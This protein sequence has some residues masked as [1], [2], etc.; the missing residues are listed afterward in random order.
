MKTEKNFGVSTP[1]SVL[2]TVVRPACLAALAAALLLSA[3][4]NLFE[5]GI[6][7]EV[8]IA[9]PEVSVETPD[10]GAFIQ[11]EV[12]F[13]GE[14]SDDREVASVEISFDRGEWRHV[15]SFEPE[16]GE[17]SYDVDTGEFPDGPLSVRARATD[18]ADKTSTTSELTYYVDNDAPVV[19]VTAPRD[20]ASRGFNTQVTF[21]VAAADRHAIEHFGVEVYD[22]D[23]RLLGEPVEEESGSPWNFTFRSEE[24]YPDDWNGEPFDFFFYFYAENEGE[25]RSSAFYHTDDVRGVLDEGVTADQL[26]ARLRSDDDQ[27]G[28]LRET[29][30]D[31][32]RLLP[33][34][35]DEDLDIPVIRI[36]NPN[37]GE[38]NTDGSVPAELEGTD[39]SIQ[40]GSTILGSVRDDDALAPGY[41]KIKLWRAPDEGAENDNEPAEWENLRP[42]DDSTPAM[43]EFEYDLDSDMSGTYLLRLK[44]EDLD[45]T[46][47]ETPPIE[48]N[49]TRGAPMLRFTEPESG[50]YHRGQVEIRGV[51]SHGDVQ[52]ELSIRFQDESEEEDGWAELGRAP[53][54]S[55]DGEAWTIVLVPEGTDGAPEGAI[56]YRDGTRNIEVRAEV[57]ESVTQTL[58]LVFDNEPPEVAF[59]TPSAD[60]VLNGLYRV[61]GTAADNQ[62]VD[63]VYLHMAPEGAKAPES[64]DD[65]NLTVNLSGV[66]S[67]NRIVDTTAAGVGT[68]GHDDYELHVQAVDRAGNLGD[69]ATVLI[70]VDQNANDPVFSF[71]GLDPQGDPLENPG[72]NLFSSDEDA[73]SYAR[74]SGTV[75]DDDG[76]DTI[77]VR[78]A[79]GAP[80]DLSEDDWDEWVEIGTFEGSVEAGID[81]AI[82]AYES[83]TDLGFSAGK[84]PYSVQFQATDIGDR[85]N[86]DYDEYGGDF[87]ALPPVTV[88]SDAIAFVID[89]ENPTI[90]LTSLDTAQATVDEPSEIPG[91]YLRDS[92]TL[93][94]EADD[95]VELQTV[96][97]RTRQK[98][99]DEDDEWDG[100]HDAELDGSSPSEWSF[101]WPHEDTDEEAK[102]LSG[103]AFR[104]EYRA[105]DIFGK[106]T[107]ND[108]QLIVDNEPPEVQIDR[109]EHQDSDGEP[110]HSTIE[111]RGTA[112]DDRRVGAVYYWIGLHGDETGSDVPEH[113][114]EYDDPT[115]GPWEQ[116]DSNT[117]WSYDWDTYAAQ[118]ETLGDDFEEDYRPQW[119][120][121]HVAAID[122]A[123]NWI[124][125]VETVDVFVDQNA[126]RPEIEVTNI[127]PDADGEPNGEDNYFGDT[128]VINGTLRAPNEMSNDDGA[129]EVRTRKYDDGTDDG[130]WDQWSGWNPI[131]EEAFTGTGTF[132]SFSYNISGLGLEEGRYQIAFRVSDSEHL[133]KEYDYESHV[134]TWSTAGLGVGEGEDGYEDAAPNDD[135]V[136]DF[137]LNRADPELQ[138][139]EPAEG[140]Y[141]NETFTLSGS[142]EDFFGVET[143]EVRIRDVDDQD[144]WSERYEVDDDSDASSDHWSSWTYDFEVGDLDLAEGENRIEV[145]ATDVFGRTRERERTVVFDESVPGAPDIES[146]VEVV[147]GDGETWLSGS[148]RTA[149]GTAQDNVSGIDL[150]EWR[151]YGGQYNEDYAHEPDNP[152]AGSDWRE[153]SGGTQDGEYKWDTSLNLGEIG[154]GRKT[155]EVRAHDR[156]GNTSD[157]AHVVFGV[158][159]SDPTVAETEIGS[160]TAARSD[161]FVLGGEIAD[162][163]EL[164]TVSV[165]QE[166]VT[167]DE[168]DPVDVYSGDFSGES[169]SWSVGSLPRDPEA[170]DPSEASA[171]DL[172]DGL[173]LYTVTVT[174]VAGRT[175][176]LTREI[177][178]DL[179][180]PEVVIGAPPETGYRSGDATTLDGTV[181]DVDQLS[182][183]A[184]VRYWVGEQGDTPPGDVAGGDLDE[185]YEVDPT[186]T[187]QGEA[188]WNDS[189]D[190]VEIGEGRM[191]LH[192]VALDEAG[193]W[194]EE[195]AT[196][197]FIVDQSD[198]EV[199]ITEIDGGEISGDTIYRNTSFSLG[200]TASDD[201]ELY[202]VRIYQNDPDA[203]GDPIAKI[204]LTGETSATWSV[205][206]LPRDPDSPDDPIS[207]EDLQDGEFE[208]RVDVYDITAETGGSFRSDDVSR[209]IT[210]DVTPPA[211]G[212]G[213]LE[214]IVEID[215]DEFLN[216]VISFAADVSS[217]GSPLVH[218]P[219]KWWILDRDSDVPTFDTEFPT[220]EEAGGSFGA[221]PYETDFDTTDLTD[222]LESDTGEFTIYFVAKDE[223]G[224]E[225]VYE[226]DVTIDQTS[227]RPIITF[228]PLEDNDGYDPEGGIDDQGAYTDRDAMSATGSVED[229]DGLARLQYRFAEEQDWQTL[230]EWDQDDEVTSYDWELDL[231]PVQDGEDRSYWLRAEDTREETEY[232]YQETE[233]ESFIVSTGSPEVQITEPGTGSWFRS[234]GTVEAEGTAVID[235]DLVDATVER[236]EYRFS[237]SDEDPGV[238]AEDTDEGLGEDVSWDANISIP[239]DVGD[240]D[241]RL[242]VRAIADNG[243]P[244]GWVSRGIR[245]DDEDPWL[246]FYDPEDKTPDDPV[247]VNRT[248]ELSGDAFDADSG[249]LDGSMRLFVL[250]HDGDG[251][252]ELA[253]D[254]TAPWS[255]ELDTTRITHDD[256]DEIYGWGE[257]IESGVWEVELRGE[258]EDNAGNVGEG[259][260]SLTIDQST[261]LPHI[262]FTNLPEDEYDGSPLYDTRTTVNLEVTDDDGVDYIEYRYNSDDDEHW[263]EIAGSGNRTETFSIPMDDHHGDNIPDGENTIDVRA[264]DIQGGIQSQFTH[265]PVTFRLN[266]SAPD[267]QLLLPTSDS[268]QNSGFEVSGT[269]Q[270][271]NDVVEVRVRI[272]ELGGSWTTANLNDDDE[273]NV[274]LGTEGEEIDGLDEGSNTI[275]VE[276]EDSAGRIADT[277]RDFTYD[278]TPPAIDIITPLTA[279]EVNGEVEI[280][281][282]VDGNHLDGTAFYIGRTDTVDPVP[283]EY[284]D[285]AS[286][287]RITIPDVGDYAG[288]YD[289]VKDTGTEG[290]Y[291]LPI[292]LRSQDEA[293]N[294]TETEDYYLNVDPDGDLPDVQ[295]IEPTDGDMIG[296]RTRI[297]GTAEDD[298]AVLR[299]EIAFFEVDEEGEFTENIAWHDKSEWDDAD[300]SAPEPLILRDD[301]DGHDETFDD[302][303]AEY[304]Y[305]TEPST[306]SWSNWFQHI[307]TYGEFNPTGDDDVRELG[308]RVRGIDTKDGENPGIQG[309][310]RDIVVSVSDGVPSIEDL[311]LEPNQ[312]VGGDVELGGVVSDLAGLE[313]FTF[314]GQSTFS[315]TWNLILNE[316]INE[317]DWIH[318]IT[319]EEDPGYREDRVSYRFSIPIDTTYWHAEA[320]TLSLRLTATSSGTAGFSS[321]SDFNVYVDN[322]DPEAALEEDEEPLRIFDDQDVTG[323]EE[324][325]PVEMAGSSYQLD[326]TAD[327]TG[328]VAGLTGVAV[329][330]ED[331]DG[332]IHDLRTE[333]YGESREDAIDGV[334]SAEDIEEGTEYMIVDPGSTDFNDFRDEFEDPIRNQTG[335]TFTAVRDGTTGDGDGTV[336]PEHYFALVDNTEEFFQDDSPEGDGDGFPERLRR[337]EDAYEWSVRLDSTQ[338]PDGEVTVHYIAL[339][340]V[341]NYEVY[342]DT[343]FVTNDRP[344]TNMVAIATDLTGNNEI[345]GDSEQQIHRIDEATSIDV[346]TGFTVR[347]SR[348]RFHVTA[349]NAGSDSGAHFQVHYDDGTELVELYSGSDND[350]YEGEAYEII[351]DESDFD[352]NGLP[353][354]VEDNEASFVVSVIDENGIPEQSLLH[355]NLENED[356]VPPSIEVSPFGRIWTSDESHGDK[357]QQDVLDYADNI[358]TNGL[359]ELLGYVQYSE[360]SNND[361]TTEGNPDLSGKV[362][363]TGRA[364]DNQRI[365][366]I[367]VE[368]PGYD[369]GAG[370]GQRFTIA[371][372]DDDVGGMAAPDGHEMDDIAGGNAEWAFGVQKDAHGNSSEFVTEAHGHVLN[373][374]FAWNTAEIANQAQLDNEITFHIHDTNPDNY[375]PAETVDSKSVDIVPYISEI[376]TPEMLEGGL[377]Q[378]NLRSADGKYSVIR[379]D[380]DDF[381]QLHGFNLNPVDN[382][383]RISPVSHP[384]G[385]DDD[386]NL[387]GQALGGPEHNPNTSYTRLGITNDSAQS[388]YLALIG[389]TETDPVP[390][391]NNISDKDRQYN[392]EPDPDVRR[393]MTLTNERYIR[394]FETTSTG[395]RNGYFPNMI[396]DG[397]ELVFGYIDMSADD[398]LQ[399]RRAHFSADG[400]M[401]HDEPLIRGMAGAWDQ[402]AM[403]R[404]ADGRYIHVSI[405]NTFDGQ[406]AYLYDEYARH[407]SCWRYGGF[408]GAG[409][410]Y[411]NRY[412]GNYYT[413]TGNNALTFESVEYGE[414]LL[415]D[416]FARPQIAFEGNSDT[417][418]GVVYSAYYDGGTDELV[419]RVFQIGDNVDTETAMYT[420][421]GYN[422]DANIATIERGDTSNAPGRHTLSTD[423]SDYFDIGVTSDERMVVAYYDEQAAQLMLDYTDAGVDGDNP[424]NPLNFTEDPVALGSEHEYVG[425]DVSLAIDNNDRVHL[426]AR[427][428]LNSGLVYIRFDD[429]TDDQPAVVHDIDVSGSLGTWTDI[430]LDDEGIPHISYYNSAET[431]SREPVRFAYYKGDGLVAADEPGVDEGGFTTGH[432]E[433]MTVPALE[434]PQGGSPNFEQVNLGFNTANEPIV[435]YLAEDIE[436]SR[437]LP[438]VE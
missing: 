334:L 87:D 295:Y 398:D 365:E 257:E 174:D 374:E 275:E 96:E 128:A 255:A 47:V 61:R 52:P 198:P 343:A 160:A 371:E 386:G 40:T 381:I 413:D 137:A 214:R 51:A 50:T 229:V 256:E 217:V 286:N 429:V 272:A 329:Y 167:G 27:A 41:P 426:A 81:Y 102:N 169:A 10:V 280:I 42:D 431:G 176:E 202:E 389:G 210:I 291:E 154:E 232:Y 209:T 110:V 208:Y 220:G 37:I 390:A 376:T 66:Y 127:D 121:V 277:S 347:N 379:G 109:P 328:R 57:E 165:T 119:F 76:V 149:E 296:G 388:G 56:E 91:S 177:T 294:T 124:E 132:E 262:E 3:C 104:V 181:T 46:R 314:R 253:V 317:D 269:A 258:V 310:V 325:Y 412:E 79:E 399:V 307:N 305:S 332:E 417:G 135:T 107:T 415:I 338:L 324:E 5:I 364:E 122:A 63:E 69:I 330:I 387:Q 111:I 112:E 354:V 11:G 437:P 260:Y 60:E 90:G 173:Y 362:V 267:L 143:V 138:I 266:T 408:A 116:F 179:T 38:L 12:T 344:L 432:W 284:A 304:W 148:G 97:V 320:G 433:Y 16:G 355:M 406:I 1:A 134:Y 239:E 252:E 231:S 331:R 130:T 353:D 78:F 24:Y 98:G 101:E 351:I 438:E 430:E 147:D 123:G 183:I 359:D 369:G 259:F 93:T 405:H 45:G 250:E 394:F 13:R 327:D 293:G 241:V 83:E 204:D 240:G 340:H 428:S 352:D 230:A 264:Q 139:D 133:G 247:V 299:V 336:L 9:R 113:P 311:T 233:S 32:D 22:Q 178:V 298:D 170:D 36:S 145:R 55:S 361:Y 261:N 144:S 287:P 263:T 288:D 227:D 129:L 424:D 48:I 175:A 54:H 251:E 245:V 290:I 151:W 427:D 396:M 157:V 26:A 219:V 95:D 423:A 72:E 383:V 273:W 356:I 244:S 236:I 94:G 212:L 345:D 159:Q 249:V 73:S 194:S 418:T 391:I 193:N 185:W 6:G 377:K 420:G 140:S 309:F 321:S 323:E 254:G 166:I 30:F 18:T 281:A 191:R 300:E 31:G 401:T 392:Q 312:S 35:F 142:A 414:E 14:A 358:V 199:E 271:P 283:W 131:G 419:Y 349:E 44:A 82:D 4:E 315:E 215:G 77:E 23:G 435:G 126:A 197:D 171:Y 436:F 313:S 188:E 19:Q 65:W 201:N 108:F 268:H 86:D 168:T 103:G 221:E 100:W 146:P 92:F 200:G 117:S 158:D 80:E 2:G 125:E 150:V 243:N 366:R 411:W 15:E 367:E 226:R 303:M 278:T 84:E 20:Y 333:L 106:T 308:I 409:E 276:A 43:F 180:G 350:A 292:T 235:T 318:E 75:S 163:N 25:N 21:D 152:E 211:V 385:L 422:S 218:D 99:D 378:V 289:Y 172:D 225:G 341:G 416:R 363:F 242:E 184:E 190:L 182:D 155:L 118:Q 205:D 237:G 375:D 335:T 161:E 368:I 195:I 404:D 384:A 28:E 58:S 285:S 8:D 274:T 62:I 59:E 373:W 136:L 85:L 421:D 203:T 360:H 187:G 7:D 395:L 156:A 348:L 397:D 248:V 434:P 33:V 224:N 17:W 400:T 71:S 326:G 34:Y 49:V 213:L 162:D 189:I 88:E 370:E 270:D 120:Q 67:W 246:D 64:L 114:E 339:D 70:E 74:F 228:D 115:D 402:Y 410:P 153:A 302:G 222:A 39:F 382:G 393:N 357:T 282:T 425:T 223:A 301:P 186:R 216:G 141:H 234:E 105:V 206:N 306:A 297:S 403:A 346:E 192:V 53:Y 322:I 342:E 196:R 337:G 316:S 164:A 238:I 319:D 68:D 89:D 407:H 380:N 279:A 372:W 265:D 29:A 207:S